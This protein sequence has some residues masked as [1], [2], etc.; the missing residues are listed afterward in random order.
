MRQEV[1]NRIN[2]CVKTAKADLANMQISDNEIQ[3]IIEKIKGLKSNI[4]VIDLDGNEL[5]DLGAL[6]LAEHLHDFH[7]LTELSLQFNSIGRKGAIAIF[8]LKKE[9]NNLDI[10][11]HGN[12][13]YDAGEMVEI[14]KLSLKQLR[15]TK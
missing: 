5:G 14:E 6:I 7:H 13:V 12:R 9:L 15:C 11:F 8:G 10:L 3:E 4:S 2:N 1:L